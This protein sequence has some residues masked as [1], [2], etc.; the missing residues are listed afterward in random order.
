MTTVSE[1]LKIAIVLAEH[2][3]PGPAANRCAVLSTGLARARPEI[4]GDDPITSDGQRLLGF[5]QVP[6]SVLRAA[7]VEE[8]RDMERAAR[9]LG[10]T[11]LVFLAV[12]QGLRSYQEYLGSIAATSSQELDVDAFLVCGPRKTVNRVTGRLPALR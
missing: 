11:T 2:L 3:E 9:D 1:D 4:L 12:A 6:I 5:T 7:R 8:L 10:C